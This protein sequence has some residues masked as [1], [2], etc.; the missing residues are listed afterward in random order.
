MVGQKGGFTPQNFA[1]LALKKKQQMVGTIQAFTFIHL[2]VT[3]QLYFYGKGLAV[4]SRGEFT[5][6]I[7]IMISTMVIITR[8]TAIDGSHPAHEV[9]SMQAVECKDFV[10]APTCNL[11][12]TVL[13]DTLFGE[14]KMTGCVSVAK[15]NL[16]L[17]L[18]DVQNVAFGDH[19]SIGASTICSRCDTHK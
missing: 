5:T 9:K 17:T 6:T 2:F 8:I 4:Q 1:G 18:D 12:E 16:H 13:S 7:S 11:S 14:S 19:D 10:C 3:E 15:G